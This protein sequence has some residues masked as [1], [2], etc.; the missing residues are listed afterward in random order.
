M[1]SLDLIDRVELFRRDRLEYSAGPQS[2]FVTGQLHIAISWPDDVHDI[3]ACAAEQAGT[4]TRL[5]PN[6]E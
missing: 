2:A 1:V 3:I 6:T 4:R 5:P